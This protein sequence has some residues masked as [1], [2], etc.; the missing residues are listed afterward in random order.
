VSTPSSIE[1][2]FAA[3]RISRD[4]MRSRVYGAHS[5]QVVATYWRLKLSAMMSRGQPARARS[6]RVAGS[7]MTYFDAPTLA[8]LYGEV[9][10]K[11]EYAFTAGRSRPLIIDCGANIGLSVCFFKLL[12]P[13]ARIIAFEPGDQASA[14]LRQAVEQNGWRDVTV[15]QAA[16][17]EEPGTIALYYDPADPGSPLMSTVSSRM[18]KASRVVPAVTLSSVIDGPVDFLKLDVEGAETGVLRDLARTG[19]L[20]QIGELAIEYHHH[21]STDH[22]ALGQLLSLLEDNGFG[23]SLTTDPFQPA[24][25]GSFQDVLV[26]AYRASGGV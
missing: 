4:I 1:K 15:H 7:T 20:A 26:R 13:D 18:P 14:A 17:A 10:F 8:F 22:D 6:T 24:S 12:Y 9:F 11:R 21:L 3:V 2:L 16:V 23:Y 25:R 5:R 19:R